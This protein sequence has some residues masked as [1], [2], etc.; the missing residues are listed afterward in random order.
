MITIKE[1]RER[2]GMNKDGT[3][4]EKHYANFDMSGYGDDDDRSNEGNIKCRFK[5]FKLLKD[6]FKDVFWDLEFENFKLQAWKGNMWWGEKQTYFN[7]N[8]VKD[9][10]SLGTDDII[11]WLA[12][13]KPYPKK[14]ILR[15]I[16]KEKRFEVLKRQNWC[17]NQC[18]CKLKY[19]KNND[20][21]AE[22]AHIDHIHP[23]SKKGTYSNG[24]YNINENSNLQALC[25]KCNLNKSK[26]Q[27]H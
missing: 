6:N 7:Y 23:F 12:K 3:L 24:A 11:F 5:N 21:V 27:I 8:E 13:N 16:S 26:K 17:C 9:F 1:I 14:E 2:I 25:P 22:V 20:W 19:S 18:G 10:S 4:G 15:I